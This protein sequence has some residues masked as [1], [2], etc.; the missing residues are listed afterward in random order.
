M[1]SSRRCRVGPDDD[2]VR[3]AGTHPVDDLRQARPLR[4]QR[5]TRNVLLVEVLTKDVAVQADPILRVTELD[6]RRSIAVALAAHR[7]RH[8]G[9]DV[10]NKRA[11]FWH[12]R[13]LWRV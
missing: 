3:Q 2:A 12:T 13:L 8:A 1:S 10:K 6:I 7:A 11:I 5:P 4:E 9:Q